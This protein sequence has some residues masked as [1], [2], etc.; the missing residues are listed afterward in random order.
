MTGDKNLLSDFMAFI[1]GYVGFAG[2]KG[3]IFRV[4]E[5]LSPKG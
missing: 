4:K 3:V 2:S 1:G 5:K